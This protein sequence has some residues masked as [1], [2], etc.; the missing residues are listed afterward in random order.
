MQ[1]L[2]NIV[3]LFVMLLGVGRLSAQVRVAEKP[4]P[5]KTQLGIPDKPG[6]GYVLLPGRWVWHR[7]ARMY[8]WLSPVWV[9]PPEGKIWVSG[10]WKQL[11]QGWIWIPGKWESKRRYWNRLRN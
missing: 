3:L 6:E 8:V 7:H 1:N 2:L 10:Y 5:P 11:R 9:V 4:V